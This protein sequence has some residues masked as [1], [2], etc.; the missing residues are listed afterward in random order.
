MLRVVK[1][2]TKS[3]TVDKVDKNKFVN[4]ILNYLKHRYDSEMTQ[5]EMNKL[6]KIKNENK[7]K[8]KLKKK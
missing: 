3:L 6:L 4:T 1:M 8:I 2:P 7:I 5:D